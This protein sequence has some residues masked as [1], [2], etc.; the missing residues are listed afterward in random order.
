MLVPT[1]SK[2]LISATTTNSNSPLFQSKAVYGSTS[3]QLCV[4]RLSY[5]QIKD[6][7]RTLFINASDDTQRIDWLH[8]LF[9]NISNLT[10]VGVDDENNKRF[11]GFSHNNFSGFVITPLRISLVCIK[12]VST[13]ISLSGLENIH[14]GALNSGEVILTDIIMAYEDPAHRVVVNESAEQPQVFSL[15]RFETKVKNALL[16]RTLLCWLSYIGEKYKS[17]HKLIV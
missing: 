14:K 1:C 15:E 3:E 4:F 7:L 9:P 13:Y 6:L 11:F 16:E 2:H 17:V 12:L 8:N 10:L 5:T